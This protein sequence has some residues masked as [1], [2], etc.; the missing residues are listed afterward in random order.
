MRHFMGLKFSQLTDLNPAH[1]FHLLCMPSELLFV[2]LKIFTNALTLL[3]IGH[4]SN[5][6]ATTITTDSL[7]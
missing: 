3:L 4:L 7:G 2:M 5:L 6:F 1:G